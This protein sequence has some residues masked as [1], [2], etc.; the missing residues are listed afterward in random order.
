MWATAAGLSTLAALVGFA[1]ASGVREQRPPAEP[2]PLP[3]L[4]AAGRAE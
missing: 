3:V 1:L 2:G 4:E